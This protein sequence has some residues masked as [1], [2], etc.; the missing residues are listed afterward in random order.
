MTEAVLK[1][2]REVCG[3]EDCQG[4]YERREVA[5]LLQH[6]GQTVIVDRVPLLVC[7]I[8]GHRQLGP[9]TLRRIETAIRTADGPTAWVPVYGYKS[10]L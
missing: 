5:H 9:Q 10:W 8:C 7:P 2:V 3:V 1:S 6:E 4:V